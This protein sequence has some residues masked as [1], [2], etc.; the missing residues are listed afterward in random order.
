MRRRIRSPCTTRSTPF[1]ISNCER[2]ASQ[3][4]LV[5]FLRSELVSWLIS[6][7]SGQLLIKVAR[8]FFRIPFSEIGVD[9][10]KFV[11]PDSYVLQQSHLVCEIE[12]L[13]GRFR[14][15]CPS[16]QHFNMLNS[17]VNLNSLRLLNRIMFPKLRASFSKTHRIGF[18]R[19]PRP[20]L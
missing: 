7:C 16:F 20:V 8:D 1:N 13:G 19:T 12:I 9:S 14:I 2:R 6:A 5:Y 15:S 10:A 4:K 17:L 11:M 18:L 3:M